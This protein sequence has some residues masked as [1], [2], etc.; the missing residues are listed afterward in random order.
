MKKLLLLTA[1]FAVMLFTSCEKEETAPAAKGTTVTYSVELPAIQTKAGTKAIGDGFNV[2]QLV[3]EVWKTDTENQRDLQEGE[4]ATRLYQGKATMSKIDGEQKCVIHLDLVHDQNYTILFWAQYAKAEGE[5]MVSPYYNTSN[6]ISVGYKNLGP[7]GVPANYKSNHENM[8]AFYGAEFINFED[9]ETA[10]MRRAV[11]KRP[12]AQLNIGTKN[13]PEDY[14]VTMKRS[15]VTIKDVPTV[16]NVAENV[17]PEVADKYGIEPKTAVSSEKTFVFDYNDADANYALPTDPNMLVVN[18]TNYHYV[19]MNYVFAPSHNVTVDYAVKATLTADKGN[20]NITDEVVVSKE[21]LEVPLKENYRTNIVGNLLSSTA[22][23]EVVIDANWD[24]VNDPNLNGDGYVGPVVGTT[25]EL[26]QAINEAYNGETI[27]ING[28]VVMPYFTNKSLK[29]VGIE[30]KAIVKQSPATH[31]DEYYKG[32][33]LHFKNVTLV[34]TKYANNTQGYQK[35]VK[36][37]YT[38]CNFIDYIMFAGDVTIV[39]NCTFTGN[40]D[41]YFWTATADNITFN[42]CTFTT[43]IG[44]AIKVCT[45]GNDGERIVKFNNCNFTATAKKKAAIEIDGTKGSSYTVYINN[46]TETGFAAGEQSGETLFNV[47]G[48]DKVTV[49]V[50]GNKWSGNGLFVGEN[51]NFTVTQNAGLKS[52]VS[53]ENAQVTVKAGNYTFPSS[54]FAEGVVM[55]CEPGTVFTGTSKLNIKGATVE[56]ATFSNPNGSAADQTI[57]GIF[58]NCTFDGTN[59]LRWAYAGE[60]VVFENCIFTGD[61]YGAHFDGGANDILF[62]DCTFSG[63]NTFGAAIPLVKFDG[64]TF[65][66]NNRSNYNGANLWGSTEMINTKFEF[67]GTCD[68]EWIDACSNDKSY[69]FTDCKLNNGSIINFDYLS[70]RNAGTKI[71]I[72]GVDYTWSDGGYLVANGVATV[73]NASGLTG[74]LKAGL[75]KIAL[76]PGTYEGTFHILEKNN[77]VNIYSDGNAK[78]KG[79]VHINS[80][81]ATFNKIM[82]DRNETDSNEPNNTAS[83][84]LQY[85]AVVMIYGDQTHTIKFDECKFYN[86]NGTHKSAITNVACNLIVDK[87]YFEGYSSSIYSQ[88][89]LS[90]TNSTFNYTGGNN[91]ILSINGCGESGGKVIFKNNNIPNKIFAMSQF[92]ST[93]GF[94]NGTYHFDVQGNTGAGFDH[95]F[96]NESRVANKTFAS[97][98]ETF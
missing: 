45:V 19:A 11:L 4:N 67:D 30:D 84:A 98:S 24:D 70:A 21:V 41:E 76:A 38:D 60:T 1:A 14:I 87:C 36:E 79:R 49:Y 34:G 48:T 22:Q 81:N 62:K 17:T 91:V 31:L 50:D 47:E 77:N 56:G 15:T 37:T 13:T 59:G 90:V 29:F 18:N 73:T 32:A 42:D 5:D 96:L 16:F 72:D 2:N 51:N 66:S 23:Y 39:N 65:K 53:T 88:A 71:T 7:D 8:A 43:K 68:Y 44:R 35:A 94:G 74:A 93:V 95:Y 86:N 83:S 52:A 6:L 20:G 33:E 58:R 80:A 9:V 55:N 12:F 26:A 27:Y 28:E 89:N 85:K 64:C 63:F 46:C 78:I 69:K 54:S 10:P 97:G 25:E 82:F 40:V 92:L 61:T 75:A 3:Y 57:N